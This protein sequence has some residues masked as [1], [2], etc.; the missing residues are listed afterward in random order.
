VGSTQRFLVL[1]Q[2]V[3]I[4]TTMH[5][6]AN[7]YFIWDKLKT[8]HVIINHC[9]CQLASGERATVFKVCRWPFVADTLCCDVK[10]WSTTQFT[11]YFRTL[12]S[13]AFC[14][15]TF[16]NASL[17]YYAIMHR[18]VLIFL[19]SLRTVLHR[20]LKAYFSV[21]WDSSQHSFYSLHCYCY[22]IL[23]A[24]T[25]LNADSI[26]SIPSVC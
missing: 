10:L 23:F 4:H 9:E 12:F 17:V 8:K 20:R 21:A 26:E 1:K 19:R 11:I 25:L 13:I 24:Q 3:H 5:Q 7:V 2:V 18:S 6:R 22:F 16:R 15:L 14:C